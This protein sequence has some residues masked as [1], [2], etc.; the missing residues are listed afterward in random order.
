VGR[1]LRKFRIDEFPQ[2]WNV[3]KGEMSL[4]GPRPTWDGETQVKDIPEYHMVAPVE[5][6]FTVGES[7]I[8]V[9]PGTRSFAEF[10]RLAGIMLDDLLA[11]RRQ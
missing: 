5:L 10:Q 1:F 3:I 8:G 2:F 4:V 11:A 9:K 7:R 6:Q